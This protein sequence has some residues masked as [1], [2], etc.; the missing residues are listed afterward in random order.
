MSSPSVPLYGFALFAAIWVGVLT[1]QIFPRFPDAL[2]VEG[3]IVTLDDYLEN[4]CA[5]RVG[6]LA[7]SCRT[8]TLETGSRLVAQRQS[9]A[10]LLIEAPLI[11]CA[12]WFALRGLWRDGSS[13]PK[14]EL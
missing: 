3:R 9:K 2:Q 11:A 5:E 6:P 4:T 1:W 13:R 14:D 12:A 8:E 10:I 7:A